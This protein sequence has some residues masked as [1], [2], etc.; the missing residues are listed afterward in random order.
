MDFDTA[1]VSPDSGNVFNIHGLYLSNSSS[2]DSYND[3][4]NGYYFYIA[5]IKDYDY[6]YDEYYYLW[7]AAVMKITN[8][9]WTFIG[10]TNTYAYNDV[11]TYNTLKV[12]TEGSNLVYYVNNVKAATII[13]A[14]TKSYDMGVFSTTWRGPSTSTYVDWAKVSSPSGSVSTSVYSTSTTELLPTDPNFSN[15]LNSKKK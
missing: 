7:Q 11:G 13:G 6:Y 1:A 9:V 5:Q 2:F 14:A 8:G 12:K 4:T 3:I 10:W 15:V